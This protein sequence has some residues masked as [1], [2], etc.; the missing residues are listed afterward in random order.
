MKLNNFFFF[1]LVLMP[2][3]L[4]GTVQVQDITASGTPVS[5][6]GTCNAA[7]IWV[8]MEYGY[9]TPTKTIWVDQV[10][11]NTNKQYSASFT[12]SQNG[13]YVVYASCQDETTTTETFCVGAAGTDCTIAPQSVCGDGSCNG[14]ET[15]SSCSADCGTCETPGGGS[16]GGSNCNPKWSCGTWSYCNASLQQSSTCYDLNKC[17]KNKLEV[18]NCTGCVESWVCSLWSDC[19]NDEEERTCV[20]EHYCGTEEQKPYLV[21]SCDVETVAGPQPSQI[22]NQLPPSQQTFQPAPSAAQ[23]AVEPFSLKEFW[24]KYNLY[25]L[26]GAIAL[27]LILIITI[28]FVYVFKPKKKAYNIDELRAW[29]QQERAVGTS[30]QDIKQILTQQTGWTE[31]EIAQAFQGSSTPRSPQSSNQSVS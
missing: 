13:N 29:V 9:G 30:D 12:P 22:T 16:P 18:K 27:V 20:D 6:T 24:E 26:I 21:K 15:C 3:A 14:G 25:I 23:P 7:N 4:A 31:E 28:L 19:E 2:L 10:T 17:E 5:I 11:A 1:L 8:S